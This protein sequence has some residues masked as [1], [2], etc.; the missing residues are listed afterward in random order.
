MIVAMVGVAPV[1]AYMRFTFSF[2]SLDGGIALLPVLLGL[3]AV[4]EVLKE[5]EASALGEKNTP[6][7]S[8]KM[9]GFFG[10]SWHEFRGQSLNLLRSST[11]GA[12]VGLLPGI[13]SGTSNLLAYLAAKN[14]SKYPEKFGTGIPDGIVASE[15]SNNA[16]IGA[17]M[18]PL[19]T[20]GIPG[21]AVTAMLLGGFLIHGI[22]P[23]PMLFQTNGAL[24]YSIFIALMVA[25]VAMI[26][27]EYYGIRLFVKLLAIPKSYLL[28][29]VMVMCVVGAFALNNRM[30][31]VYTL[32]AFGVFGY[33]LL[34][35]DY[36]FAPMI[37]GFILG[38]LIEQNLRSALM[39]GRGDL[40]P[41]IERPI[42]ALFLGAAAL[43]LVYVVV[44]NKR[45]RV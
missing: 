15:S 39:S 5:A 18:V 13:G 40:S 28:S 11:I 33:V 20:L 37:L 3:F 23:G 26:A 14:G 44:Q 45:S 34:K 24:V 9:T 7:P 36:P 43:Y 31:D 6:I 35:F 19:I 25:N 4:S 41:F 30:F 38:P 27:M 2:H 16:G 1:D 10:V 22:Q 42:S 32:F 21:D 8:F 17:A 29:V 12:A